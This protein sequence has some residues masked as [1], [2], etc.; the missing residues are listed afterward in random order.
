MTEEL[1]NT[2]AHVCACNEANV[3]RSAK[4]T[5]KHWLHVPKSHGYALLEQLSNWH[6]EFK[7]LSGAIALGRMLVG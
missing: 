5:S 2:H 3:W 6:I 4:I 7:K 1:L